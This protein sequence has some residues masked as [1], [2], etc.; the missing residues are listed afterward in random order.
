MSTILVTR[1]I[2]KIGLTLLKEAG[3]KVKLYNKSTAMP[4][5]AMLQ[6]VKGCDAMLSL[7]TDK[8]D[9]EFFIA[10][11]M[12]LKI[13]ANYAVGYDN[14]DLKAFKKRGVLAANTPMVL[15]VAV[16][17]H[18]I[19]LIMA[20]AKRLAEADRFVRGG[21]YKGWEPELLL[22]TEL[23]GKTLGVLGLGRIGADVARRAAKG[24]DMK[25]LYFDVKRN[26][27]FE[28]ELGA[29]YATAEELLKNSDVVS[30]HVPLLPTTRHLIDAKKLKLM[31]KTAILVNTSRG[32]VIDEKALVAALKAKRIAAAGLDV[33]EFEPKLVPGL[34]K[35][36]NVT[37]TPHTASATTEARDAMARIAAQGI[38]DVLAGKTPSNLVPLP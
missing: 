14:F 13:V 19:A 31:K 33:F 5:K 10:A 23:A 11:G 8:I 1:K 9:E 6:A 18:A 29:T 32:P 24:L 28:K 36:P 22:G 12:Q 37:L 35:L 21:K 15:N 38:I 34:A 26:E 2:P 7:L 27:A 17:E 3:H 25:V 30:V 20:A 16:A 4:R